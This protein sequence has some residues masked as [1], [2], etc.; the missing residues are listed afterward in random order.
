MLI[1]VCC[2]EAEML[3]FTFMHPSTLYKSNPKEKLTYRYNTNGLILGGGQ[4]TCNG[5]R[6][7]KRPTRAYSACPKQP[8]GRW[9]CN[10]MNHCRVS[11]SPCL[12][13]NQHLNESHVF[14][15]RR[16]CVAPVCVNEAPGHRVYCHWAKRSLKLICYFPC[17]HSTHSWG[18]LSVKLGCDIS[19]TVRLFIFTCLTFVFAKFT[20]IHKIP[21]I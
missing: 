11:I 20:I 10:S 2:W 15:Q 21:H 17:F 7:L 19:I 13:V 4:K 1:L 16:D 14:N 12:T 5:N 6:V 3:Q 18:N 9:C 8:K